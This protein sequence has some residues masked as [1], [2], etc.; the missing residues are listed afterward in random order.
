M[1]KRYRVETLAQ[2]S[3][4][5]NVEYHTNS[6]AV[7]EGYITAMIKSHKVRFGRVVDEMTGLVVSQEPRRRKRFR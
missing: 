5:W 1:P 4:E 3:D 2:L 7:A 6:L